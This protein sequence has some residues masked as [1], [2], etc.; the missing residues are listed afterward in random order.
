MNPKL[1]ALLKYWEQ[2]VADWH[3]RTERSA[4]DEEVS[5]RCAV[6]AYTIKACLNDL[7]LALKP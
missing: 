4:S 5:M 6:R 1:E 2:E 7:K 3:E